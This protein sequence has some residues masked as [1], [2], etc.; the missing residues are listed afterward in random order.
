MTT[1][2]RERLL[3]Q[4]PFRFCLF[5]L[6]TSLC[7]RVFQGGFY[8]S[9]RTF[10]ARLLIDPDCHVLKKYIHIHIFLWQ[11]FNLL[12]FDDFLI[13]HSY[14]FSLIFFLYVSSNDVIFF[15]C[16]TVFHEDSLDWWIFFFLSY[17]EV[18]AV[19]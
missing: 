1:N 14:Y 5:L 18:K 2:A 9:L 6:F 19:E 3:S 13:K 10:L 12:Y 7:T 16:S 17:Q 15:S 4:S 11:I 8:T